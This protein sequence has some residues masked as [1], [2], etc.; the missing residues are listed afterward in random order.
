LLTYKDS[1]LI[2][3]TTEIVIKDSFLIRKK[4]EIVIKNFF[5]AFKKPVMIKNGTHPVIPA[6][7]PV[8]SAPAPIR[9][10]DKII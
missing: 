1:L 8:I 3:K 2:N 10:K 5:P 6:S 7:S 4:R 9:F